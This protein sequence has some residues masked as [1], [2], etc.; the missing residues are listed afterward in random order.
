MAELC[1]ARRDG[2][3]NGRC[4][5]EPS[6][7]VERPRTVQMQV[8]K[9]FGG[10]EVQAWDCEVPFMSFQGVEFCLLLQAKVNW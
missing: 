3:L 5:Q 7:F 8:N 10:G 6:G 9:E 2:K 4:L 1:T